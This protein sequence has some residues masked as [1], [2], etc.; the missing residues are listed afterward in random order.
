MFATILAGYQLALSW[1][2]DAMRRVPNE[3]Y[4]PKPVIL[5]CHPERSEGSDWQATEI[6][7]FVQDDIADVDW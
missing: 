6:L 2:R 4:Q 5:A 1:C 7:R 3:F